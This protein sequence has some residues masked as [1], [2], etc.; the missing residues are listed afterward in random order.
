MIRYGPPNFGTVVAV[1]GNS[2]SHCVYD[3]RLRSCRDGGRPLYEYRFVKPP[4]PQVKKR[5]KVQKGP[6]VLSHFKAFYF[7]SFNAQV[8]SFLQTRTWALQRNQ[9][10]SQ[11]Q[12]LPFQT[13]GSG[14]GIGGG[15]V[16]KCGGTGVFLPRISSATTTADLRKK[17]GELLPFFFFFF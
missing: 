7:F 11:N 8:D 4:Q 1:T 6:F 3:C 16:R 5:E 10:R 2:E 13:S 15:F 12:S 14:L 17:Q 9:N